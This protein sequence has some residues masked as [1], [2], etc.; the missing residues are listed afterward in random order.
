MMMTSTLMH[1]WVVVKLKRWVLQRHMEMKINT[2]DIQLVNPVIVHP[3]VMVQSDPWV[4]C[5]HP[6]T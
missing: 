6:Q 4:V 3:C 1:P 5:V 2:R